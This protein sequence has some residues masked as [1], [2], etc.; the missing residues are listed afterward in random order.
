MLAPVPWTLATHH[1]PN[2]ERSNVAS[3]GRSPQE[4][5]KKGQDMNERQHSI[6]GT[7]RIFYGFLHFCMC[8]LWFLVA[9]FSYELVIYQPQ[10]CWPKI[11][12]PP[13]PKLHKK[14]KQVS[15]PFG[16]GWV[17]VLPNF[18]LEIYIY[19]MFFVLNSYN[20]SSTPLKP[21]FTAL[22]PPGMPGATPNPQPAGPRLSPRL[23]A[24]KSHPLQLETTTTRFVGS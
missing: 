21:Q 23:V 12:P 6:H 24:T 7:G 2:H 1:C 22:P 14:E 4:F 10:A 9:C 3:L 18:F 5:E 19:N 17:A 13:K 20:T 11:C 15:E 8:F 16:Y